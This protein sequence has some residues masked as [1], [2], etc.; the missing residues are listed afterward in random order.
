MG[1]FD[2]LFSSDK[3]E[4]TTTNQSQT[5]NP[6]SPQIPYLQDVFSNAQS[7][8]NTGAG[9]VYSGDQVAQ[10]TPDQ[11]NVFAQ[12]LGYGTGSNA[13][14]ISAN[15]GTNLVNTGVN[16][17]DS[18]MQRLLSFKPTDATSNNITAAG[19]YAD[20]PYLSGQVDAAMRDALR[21][22]NEQAIP[23]IQRQAAAHGNVNAN[24][25]GQG[26]I[27]E[28]IVQRGL[29]DQAG[30]ISSQLRGNA[31]NQGLQLAESARTA[32]QNAILQAL[33]STGALGASS[34]ASGVDALNSSVNQQ[35][36]LFDLA[37]TGA[38]GQQAA[39]Q[40]SIDNARAVSEYPADRL[41]SLLSQY[42]QN[43][44]GNYGGST[45]STG[46][47]TTDTQ[48]NQSFASGIAGILGS[49]AGIGKAF[50]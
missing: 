12:M 29:A 44:S 50:K 23:A 26:G 17:L 35:A 3:T 22:A 13:A 36:N 43:I 48:Q 18:A 8:Y 46:T 6:W 16:G 47:L 34:A 42:F 4:T 19:A 9:N 7:N 1:L 20:N 32:D 33:Q 5:T 45:N 31:W 28:G 24:T 37:N 14:Q 49:V 40:A 41:N 11:M 30:D 2:G 21:Y 10:Y 15:A 27:A 39:N 25:T 38:A